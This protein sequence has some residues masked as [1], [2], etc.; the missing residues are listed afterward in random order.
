MAL[1]V[2]CCMLACRN[3]AVRFEHRFWVLL[4]R[5]ADKKNYD[6]WL[7]YVLAYDELLV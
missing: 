1:P 3:Y 6:W 4:D 7:C 5:R 2:S